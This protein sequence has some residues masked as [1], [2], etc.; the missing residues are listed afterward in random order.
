ML[1]I[2]VLQKNPYNNKTQIS[3]EDLKDLFTL[4]KSQKVDEVSFTIVNPKN[5]FKDKQILFPNAIVILMEMKKDKIKKAPSSIALKEILR[6]Y[7]ELN[8]TVNKVAK[9]LRKRGYNAHAGPSLGGDVNY[10]T[11]AR[12]ASMGEI[13]KHGLLINEH[14][15][16][17]FRLAAIY[18]DIE[19]L[20]L[21]K[22]KGYSWIKDFCNTCKMCIK[23]CPVQAIYDQSIEYKDKSLSCIDYK[24]CAVPFSVDYGCT[25]CIKHCTFFKGDFNKIKET[26]YANSRDRKN[27]PSI[28]SEH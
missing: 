4:I 7:Y 19:N 2:E 8:A 6:T 23:K 21:V 24:K 27:N 16:P 12:D 28:N 17:S 22:E 15:G 3:N 5:I 25:Q 14:F 20:P 26:F 11:L 9:F 10:V 1:V 13:G 18:T